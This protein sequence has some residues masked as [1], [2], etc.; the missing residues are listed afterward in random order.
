MVYFRLKLSLAISNDLF[1]YSYHD[2]LAAGQ[3]GSAVICHRENNLYV[4]VSR[5][6]NTS[7]WNFKPGLGPVEIQDP[8]GL[9]ASC[10]VDLE[11]TC[12]K[13][14]TRHT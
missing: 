6:H 11:S 9:S 5:S 14:I 1:L 8:D 10:T 13:L 4:S 7:G 2:S 3:P 12:S